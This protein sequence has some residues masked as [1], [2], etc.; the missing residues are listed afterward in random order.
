MITITAA[1]RD[2]NDNKEICI[3]SLYIVPS[4]EKKLNFNMNLFKIAVGF[5]A[6]NFSE[7]PILSPC[8]HLVVE[9]AKYLIF[10]FG[11]N[12]CSSRKSRDW[13]I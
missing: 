2:V 11:F 12:L 5:T 9:V 4:K 13:Y 1:L 3:K 8:I 6:I 7:A 10:C